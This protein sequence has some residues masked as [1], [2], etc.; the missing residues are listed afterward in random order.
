[1]GTCAIVTG[2]TVNNGNVVGGPKRTGRIQNV[3]IYTTAGPP[4]FETIKTFPGNR[5]RLNLQILIS[6]AYKYLQI[7]DLI[8]IANLHIIRT[9][10]FANRENFPRSSARKG[11]TRCE[12]NRTGT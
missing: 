3:I 5:K 6:G 8:G 2:R 10:N 12:R 11:R 9:V 7:I 4:K 1:M